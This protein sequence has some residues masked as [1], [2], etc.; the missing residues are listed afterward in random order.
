[1][2][3]KPAR[4]HPAGLIDADSDRKTFFH[5]QLYFVK[6]VSVNPSALPETIKKGRETFPVLFYVINRYQ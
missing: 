6:A 2:I 4:R 5:R 1:M 3:S